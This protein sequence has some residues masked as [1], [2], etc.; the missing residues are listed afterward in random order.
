[1]PIKQILV[2]LAL[3]VSRKQGCFFRQTLLGDVAEQCL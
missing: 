2:V 3:A 1:M